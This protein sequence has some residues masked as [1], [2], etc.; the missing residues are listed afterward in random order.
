M[1]GAFSGPVDVPDTC[2]VCHK[3]VDPVVHSLGWHQGEP[4]SP[5]KLQ[6]VLRCP[7]DDCQRIFLASYERTNLAANPSQESGCWLFKSCAPFEHSAREFE[8][9]V[10]DASLAFVRIY[11]QAAQA[12]AL[13]L[14]DICG[15]GYR[16]AL[17]FLIKDYL[18]S[19]KRLDR[20][21]IEGLFL[22]KCIK[23]HVD[24]PRV[25]SSAERAAWLGNDETHYVRRWT[26]KDVSDLKKL[27]ELTVHWIAADILTKELES[28]MPSPTGPAATAT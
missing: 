14:D 25:K 17:E 24:D 8:K 20:T 23:D 9:P 1:K 13:G 4:A 2:P 10:H 16:K 15:A 18:I 27:I 28:S 6:V 19:H 26:D 12:E 11:G 22:G 5:R 3:G 21:E 7:R